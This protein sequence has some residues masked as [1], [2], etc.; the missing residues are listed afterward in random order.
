MAVPQQ[1]E[2]DDEQYYRDL[3]NL[4]CTLSDAWEYD[5]KELDDVVLAYL[6]LHL[7]IDVTSPSGYALVCRGL[8]VSV[9][10]RQV[11]ARCH[12]LP[13]EGTARKLSTE[14][15]GVRHGVLSVDLSHEYRPPCPSRGDYPL[16]DFGTLVRTDPLYADLQLYPCPYDRDRHRRLC[17]PETHPLIE[18]K[19]ALHV[20][21]L[22]AWIEMLNT[23][24]RVRFGVYVRPP[25]LRL[26]SPAEAAERVRTGHKDVYAF[27]TSAGEYCIFTAGVRFW[28]GNPLVA[29]LEVD[30]Q[31]LSVDE[32]VRRGYLLFIQP[33]YE[34]RDEA[35]DA[36]FQLRRAVLKLV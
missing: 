19:G 7:D 8:S 1:V 3:S 32:L 5:R 15:R 34:S 35:R 21:L 29:A 31:E 11:G 4:V 25:S 16:P 20:E 33:H 13:G 27:T 9:A 30:A 14:P 18:Q 26:L 17:I 28:V 36:L 23:E 24:E 6:E 22:Q 2:D 10:G 12:L